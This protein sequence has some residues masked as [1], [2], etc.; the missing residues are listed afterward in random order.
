MIWG[1][2]GFTTV[3]AKK[4]LWGLFGIQRRSVECL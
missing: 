4:A 3:G 2:Y 1:S